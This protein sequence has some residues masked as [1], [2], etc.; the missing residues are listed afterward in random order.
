MAGR[1]HRDFDRITRA[2]H[3][4][5]PLGEKHRTL[6]RLHARFF[7]MTTVIQPDAENLAGLEWGEELGN[8]G[9]LAGFA[10]SAVRVSVAAQGGAVGF[11]RAEM[12]GSLRVLVSD[13][14]HSFIGNFF[15]CHLRRTAFSNSRDQ[16][17]ASANTS[18]SRASPKESQTGMVA[19]LGQL[20]GNDHAQ[21]HRDFAVLQAGEVG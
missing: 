4:V 14:V 20:S 3:G 6:G 15:F 13:Y 2:G 16:P 8:L 18:V 19:G 17:L 5:D 9:G 11:L 12:N 21:S 1:L 10:E 7:G